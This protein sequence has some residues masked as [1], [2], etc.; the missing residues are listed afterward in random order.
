MYKKACHAGNKGEVAS[1]FMGF[2]SALLLENYAQKGLAFPNHMSR[3]VTKPVCFLESVA[4]PT[5][6]PGGSGLVDV[7]S[8]L[9]L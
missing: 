6:A 7:M 3:D 2:A 9:H 5:W 1:A 8:F 4:V